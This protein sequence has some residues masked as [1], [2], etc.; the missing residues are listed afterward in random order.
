IQVTAAEDATM[1]LRMQRLHPAVHH[2]REAGVISDFDG[3]DGI[4]TQQLVGAAGGQDF[5]ALG[6]ELLGEVDDTGL[7]RGTDPRPAYRQAGGLVG[8]L[9]PYP[10]GESSVTLQAEG[11]G[12]LRAGRI[13]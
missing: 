13:V 12:L 5:H 2:F 3:I 6:T 4:V 11:V 10:V 9:S 1:D 7:V 8:N